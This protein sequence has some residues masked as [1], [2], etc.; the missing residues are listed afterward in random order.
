MKRLCIFCGS[1]PGHDPVYAAGA[2][3]LG[4][5]IARA[6]IGLVYGGGRVGLMGIVADAAMAAGGEAIGVIPQA[7]FDREVGHAGLT[8]LRV[9]GSM[10]ERKAMMA[11]LADG[12]VALPGGIGTLEELFE[13]WTW[14][15]LGDHRKPVALMNI[16]GFYDPLTAFLDQLV[17]AGFFKPEHRAMLI[18]GT[19]PAVLIDVMRGY[20]P[21]EL[22][23]WIEA[24][25]R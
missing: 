20:A 3:A 16:A 19:D 9:V 23:K 22:G 17:T 21:P 1:S 4:E 15:Q 18:A 7:L 5:T 24:L 8:E 2:R 13:I 12:F 14:G 11:D 25:E 6:G 10:H